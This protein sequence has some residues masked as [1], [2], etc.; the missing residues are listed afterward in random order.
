MAAKANSSSKSKRRAQRRTFKLIWRDV[1]LRIRHQRNY[2]TK[3]TDHVEI[4]VV[5]P[6]GA[7][8]PV[9]ETGYRSHFI[10]TAD[11]KAAGG[12]LRFVTDWL[13][14]EAKSRRWIEADLKSRQGDLF[15]GSRP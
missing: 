10:G 5:A 13:D 14:R 2:L 1:T 11:L 7:I 8:L 6:E 4:I 15:P 3:G 12:P 9:T